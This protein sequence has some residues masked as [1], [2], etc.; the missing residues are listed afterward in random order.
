M[1][2]KNEMMGSTFMSV[3][4]IIQILNNLTNTLLMAGITRY[5]V[6]GL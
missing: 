2:R 3:I 5:L 6:D 4:P 1:F